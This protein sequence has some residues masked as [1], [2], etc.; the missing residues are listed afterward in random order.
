[1]AVEIVS[2][3][4]DA[5]TAPREDTGRKWYVH[6]AG[7]LCM[8]RVCLTTEATPNGIGFSLDLESCDP[9]T[10]EKFV[11]A[12]IRGAKLRVR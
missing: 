3:L 2:C 6:E 12:M 4:T 9:D 7:N 11:G 5:P 8:G 10:R 1:M